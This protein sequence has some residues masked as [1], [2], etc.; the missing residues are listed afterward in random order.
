MTEEAACRITANHLLGLQNFRKNNPRPGHDY[1]YEL[2][3][4]MSQ[5]V[6][7]YVPKDPDKVRATC[8]RAIPSSALE[9][10]IAAT[11]WPQTAENY[12]YPRP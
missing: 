4:A 7:K 12:Y 5:Y 3:A 1:C 11:C 9:P 6:R 2:Q 10:A 8:P